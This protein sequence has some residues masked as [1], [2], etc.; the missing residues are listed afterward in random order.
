MTQG[1][2]YQSQVVGDEPVSVKIDFSMGGFAKQGDQV[3]IFFEDNGEFIG[4]FRQSTNLECF[5]NE[6][7]SLG[8]AISS[9]D[10]MEYPLVE[11]LLITLPYDISGQVFLDIIN[12][13]NPLDTRPISEGA[14]IRVEIFMAD[15]VSN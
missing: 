4:L 3:Q 6:E 7:S 15:Q 12:V 1:V 9:Y 10:A 5:I 11:Y 8:C 13:G 14:K 2:Q